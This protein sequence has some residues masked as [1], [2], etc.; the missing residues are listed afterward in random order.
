MA[1]MSQ[2]Y[3]DAV[4]AIAGVAANLTEDQLTQ[5]VPAAPA[6]TVHDLLAHL[7]GEAA[8]AVSGELPVFGPRDDDRPI[9]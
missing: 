3:D 4:S 8:D 6:W 1:L 7:A 5:K 9:P 2:V